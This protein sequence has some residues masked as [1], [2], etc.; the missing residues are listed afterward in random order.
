MT[1]GHD[2]RSATYI[3]RSDL[4]ELM[5]TQWVVERCATCHG[6]GVL[7]KHYPIIGDRKYTCPACNGRGR[8]SER[9]IYT[10]ED[11]HRL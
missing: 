9:T 6:N 7:Y 1:S 2:F 5:K 11:D 8:L 10:F 4:S 3:C